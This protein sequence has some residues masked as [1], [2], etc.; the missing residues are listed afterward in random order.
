MNKFTEDLVNKLIKAY[1][2]EGIRTFVEETYDGW[3]K[4]LMIRKHRAK[5][6][7]SHED[8]I[9]HDDMYVA[10]CIMNGKKQL[11]AMERKEE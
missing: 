10:E 7:I 5:V 8:L 3:I 4:I 6:Y 1:E 9:K 2:K 11:E